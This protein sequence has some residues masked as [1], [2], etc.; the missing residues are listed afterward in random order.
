MAKVDIYDLKNTQAI[1]SVCGFV[2]FS[3]RQ[4]SLDHSMTSVENSDE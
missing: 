2:S 1:N 4:K 3:A